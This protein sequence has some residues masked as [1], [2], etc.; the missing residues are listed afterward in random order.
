MSDRV[1]SCFL[2]L[3]LFMFLL[4]LATNVTPVA[5]LEGIAAQSTTVVSE[6]EER[7]M[8]V[9][10]TPHGPIAIDGDASFSDTALLEGWPGDGSP[11]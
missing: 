4:T 9:A 6:P 8:L 11:E 3:T 10:G 2:L 5:D 7:G 1:S